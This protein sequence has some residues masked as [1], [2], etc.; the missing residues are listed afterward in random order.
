[1][2]L[3]FTRAQ[4]FEVFAAYNAAVW[5]AVILAYSLAVL[6]LFVVLRGSSKAQLWIGAVLALL[7]AWVGFVYHGFFFSQ[8]NPAA[9]VFA[10]AFVV[11]AGLFVVHAAFAGGLEFG[12]AHRFRKAIGAML[13][14]YA[15]VAYPMIGLLAGERYPAMPLFGIAPC[16][17]L[18]FT[19]GLFV[20][21]RN[22]RWWLWIVPALWSLVGG[23]AAILLSVEQDWVL[24]IAAAVALG[25]KLADRR[26]MAVSR[27]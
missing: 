20:W 5:P 26:Q 22:A 8:I 11:Q 6:A 10:A 3:P 19:F 12:Q 9:R 15:M 7:W 21:A 4:F 16:P 14:F 23:S 27:S 25:V 24:P 1:M 2:M 17:L 18:I 13:I